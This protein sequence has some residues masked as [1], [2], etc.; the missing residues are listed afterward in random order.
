[1]PINYKIDY[2]VFYFTTTIISMVCIYVLQLEKGKYYV[3]KTNNPNFRIKSHF[4]S[5]GSKWTQLYK[6]LKM[7][8]LKKNCDDYDEDKVTRQYMDKYGIDN[9]RGGSFVS[10]KLD[11]SVINTLQQ[12]EIGTNDKC[13]KCGEK[14]HFAKDCNYDE[15]EDDEDEWENLKNNFI[16][17]S[18]K[19]KMKNNIISGEDVVKIMNNL[20][21]ELKLTNVYATCQKIN[22]YSDDDISEDLQPIGDYRTGINYINFIDGFIYICNKNNNNWYCQ[23]CNKSFDTKKGCLFHENIYCKKKQ[24]RT[25]KNSNIINCD[26]D[27]DYNFSDDEF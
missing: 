6:P 2:F 18:K 21:I 8:E 3:G 25:K 20:G 17:E 9:V 23:Y 5:N 4:N 22:K 15:D 13:F 16:S 24:K 12:M 10:V 19:I 27:D 1:M 26:S 14:G 11:N 7:V